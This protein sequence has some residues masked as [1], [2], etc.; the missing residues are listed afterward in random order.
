MSLRLNTLVKDV[1]CIVV[2]SFVLY[3]YFITRIVSYCSFFILV[4]SFQGLSVKKE[5]ITES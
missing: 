1:G 3:F 4:P 5:S 2:S